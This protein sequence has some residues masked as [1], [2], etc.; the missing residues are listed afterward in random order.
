MY[1]R[2][3]LFKTVLLYNHEHQIL[4]ISLDYGP[5]LPKPESHFDILFVETIISTRTAFNLIMKCAIKVC[6]LLALI[7]LQG[8]LTYTP[9]VSYLIKMASVMIMGQFCITN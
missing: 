9:R 1:I 8:T 7:T 2:Q 5:V 3:L 6:E 4:Q